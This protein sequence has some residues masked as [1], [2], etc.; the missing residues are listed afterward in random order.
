[1]SAH[2]D[3]VWGYTTAAAAVAG[4]TAAMRA[5]EDAERHGAAPGPPPPRS[6]SSLGA[7]ATLAMCVTMATAL[8]CSAP[9]QWAMRSQARAACS[10]SD[11]C[12]TPDG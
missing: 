7:V 10:C 12:H 11:S 9:L 2:S 6:T 3:D 8:V 1:M 5:L 4:I